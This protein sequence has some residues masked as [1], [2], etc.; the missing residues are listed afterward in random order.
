[1]NHQNINDIDFRAFFKNG[2]YEVVKFPNVQVF[3]EEGLIG[4]AYSSSYVPAED[5]EAGKQFL[6]LLQALFEKYN[7]NRTVM[8]RYETEVYTGKV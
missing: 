7:N 2:E 3:D 1:V 6:P 4:R 5:T 8:F